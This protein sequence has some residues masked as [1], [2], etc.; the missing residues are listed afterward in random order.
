MPTIIL[1]PGSGV[2]RPRVAYKNLFES[3]DVTITCDSEA[4]DYAHQNAYDWL[5]HTHW[6]PETGG[7]HWIQLVFGTAVSPNYFAFYGTDLAANG[8]T[9]SLQYSLNSGADWLDISSAVPADSAPFY[10]N[11]EAIESTYWRVLMDSIDPSKIAVLAF[12]TDLEM[13]RGQWIGVTPPDLGRD[14][15]LTTIVSDAGAFLGRSVIR[16]LWR[17]KIDLDF[18]SFGWVYEKWLPFMKH[19]ELKPFFYKWNPSDYPNTTAFSWVEKRGDIE[20]PS[21]SKRAMMSAG[22]KFVCNLE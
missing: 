6:M 14:T 15:D 19:A 1:D 2:A 16:N 8:G 13:E 11:F 18:L 4:D 3:D 10:E 9:I 7:P 22:I 12:G 21:I 20:K 5:P 17:T